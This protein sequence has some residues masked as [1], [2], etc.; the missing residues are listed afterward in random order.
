MEVMN[1]DNYNILSRSKVERNSAENI[2][3]KEIFYKKEI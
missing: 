3:T 2:D 1:G